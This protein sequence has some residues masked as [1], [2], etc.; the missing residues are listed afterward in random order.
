MLLVI[1]IALAGILYYMKP[2]KSLNLDYTDVNWKDKLESILETRRP[3]IT[4][5]EE[6]INN[7]AKKRIVEHAAE[8]G[9]ELEFNIEGADFHI[10]GNQLSADVIAG[11]GYLR[12]EATVIYSMAFSEGMLKLTPESVQVRNKTMSPSMFGLKTI[13]AKPGRYLPSVIKVSDIDFGANEM[14]V[15]LSV[16]WFKLPSLIW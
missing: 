11:W 12:G 8:S 13:E 10:N 14:K 4:L 3:V 2:T 1:V 9:S 16:N 7:L 6:E 15:T 5:N